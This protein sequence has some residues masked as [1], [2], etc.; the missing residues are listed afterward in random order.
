MFT[1]YR[2]EHPKTE[3]SI[4]VGGWSYV[5]AG[6][7]G[8]FWVLWMGCGSYFLRALAVNIGIFLALVAVA[9]MT[10]YVQPAYQLIALL[11]A[12]PA[13]V[14]IQSQA[15]VSLVRTAYRRRGWMTR[16]GR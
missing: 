1:T 14:V 9:G 16:I 4:I 15:M 12:V 2:F 5:W 13:A 3:Q 7:F 10:S 8:A 11:V 6:L